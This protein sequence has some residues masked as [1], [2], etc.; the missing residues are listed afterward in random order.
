MHHSIPVGSTLTRIYFAVRTSPYTMGDPFDDWDAAVIAAQAA[1]DKRLTNLAASAAWNADVH[2]LT[3]K[4]VYL[5]T[6]WV[7]A[8]NRDADGIGG[9]TDFMAERHPDVTVLRTRASFE[10]AR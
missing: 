7:M 1:Y 9:S 6:R 10:T 5:E 2:D 8:W 3:R 4:A